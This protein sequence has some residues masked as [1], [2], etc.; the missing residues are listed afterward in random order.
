MSFKWDTCCEI[1]SMVKL[2][3][4]V[5]AHRRLIQRGVLVWEGV[6]FIVVRIAVK[7]ITCLLGA[8]LFFLK[9]IARLF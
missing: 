7:N 3:N 2:F 8:D 9:Y 4:L 5:T 6:W 1:I